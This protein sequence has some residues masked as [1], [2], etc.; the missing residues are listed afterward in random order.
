M[1]ELIDTHAHVFSRKFESDLD[2]VIGRCK[3]EG[4]SKILMP[5]IDEES[6]EAMLDVERRYPD[7][8][9]PMMGIH[10]CSVNEN[11]KDQVSFVEK[12]LG[13]HKYYAVGE[14]GIDLYWDKSTEG[15]QVEALRAQVELGKSSNLPVVLHCRESID[16]TIDEIA[17]AQ[18]GSLTGVFHCFSGDAEQ[19]KKALDTGLYLGIGGVSTFKNG[20]LDKV[21]PD[22]PLDKILLETDAPYLAPVPFRGKRNSP[23]YLPYIAG[24]IA[25]YQGVEVGEVAR[26]TTKNANKLF[27]LE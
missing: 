3:S 4:I 20:G 27:G 13:E 17:K 21:L 7:Y 10:P 16:L 12:T 15:I 18:D 9:L 8:C 2:E 24:K 6:V 14:I 19:A 22:V 1:M 26:V 25:E 23:E 11:W 5:N